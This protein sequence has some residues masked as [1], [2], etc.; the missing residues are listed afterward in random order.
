MRNPWE[1]SAPHLSVLERRSSREPP[2]SRRRISTEFTKTV[3]D[4]PHLER[5]LSLSPVVLLKIRGN[6]SCLR[7]K[8]AH[9]VGLLPP[10][11]A[12]GSF[13]PC[14]TEIGTLFC[15]TPLLMPHRWP[16]L[17]RAKCQHERKASSLCRQTASFE[18]GSIR[19]C[20]A[21][22][23]KD[24]WE[25]ETRTALEGVYS[26]REFPLSIFVSNAP[27]RSGDRAYWNEALRADTQEWA[28]SAAGLLHNAGTPRSLKRSQVFRLCFTPK[29][30]ENPLK[31]G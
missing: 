13:L 1:Y 2:H 19:I 8:V 6:C 31:T 23:R 30:A 18:R 15:L 22:E 11:E 16:W 12:S 17:L 20:R 21:G 9:L 28:I 14:G 10:V 29:K 24:L 4:N 7:A 26:E 27:L 5:I 25:R 3:C